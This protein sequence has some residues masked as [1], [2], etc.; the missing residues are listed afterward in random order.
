MSSPYASLAIFDLVTDS[1]VAISTI[2]VTTNEVVL[3]GAWVLDQSQ[4]NEIKLILSG[5][6]GIPLSSEAEKKFSEDKMGY[7]KVSLA[8]FVSE[9]KSEAALGR[10]SFDKYRSEDLKKR[11]NLV[12]PEFYEWESVPDLMQSESHLDSFGLVQ[13]Y[14]GTAPEM[15]QVLA[16][17]RVLQYLILK[18]KSDELSR[19]G[20]KYVEGDSAAVTILPKSWLI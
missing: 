2:S 15:R 12:A 18:W 3:S 5:R 11:K 7:S 1:K 20:R 10:E 19:S 16:A 6:L 13:G 17:A 8:Q 14:E 9:A 4:V